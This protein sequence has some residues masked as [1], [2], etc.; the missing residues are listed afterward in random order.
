LSEEVQLVNKATAIK[1]A[2][3]KFFVFIINSFLRFVIG[4]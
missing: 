2:I 4:Y 1:E 3:N